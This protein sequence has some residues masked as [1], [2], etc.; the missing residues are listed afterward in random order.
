MRLRFVL[1]LLI[2]SAALA[3][4]PAPPDTP[5]LTLEEKISLTTDDVK[6]ADA[7]EKAQ[8]AYLE[9]IK[10]VQDHEDAAKKAIEDEHPGWT[11]EQGPQGWHFTKKDKPAP[12]K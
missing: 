3:Q 9:Q 5:A 10:P 8:K 6:K 12:K 4:Q 2:S 7:L 1:P 11:L